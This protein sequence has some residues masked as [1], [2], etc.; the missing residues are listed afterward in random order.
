MWAGRPRVGYGAMHKVQYQLEVYRCRNEGFQG[1][2][3][4]QDGRTD[5]VVPVDL[6][7]N[8]KEDGNQ[9]AFTFINDPGV[10]NVEMDAWS[11][12]A[13]RP[14]V[15]NW[16]MHNVQYQFEVNRCRNEEFQGSSANNGRTDGGDNHNTPTLFND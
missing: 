4:G 11:M 13:G 3:S 5:G 12:W 8:L 10:G 16:A 9:A 7:I 2:N 14:R 6:S 1:Y 15:D